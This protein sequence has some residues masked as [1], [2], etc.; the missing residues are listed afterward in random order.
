MRRRKWTRR[1]IESSDRGVGIRQYMTE[2]LFD[3]ALST[4]GIMREAAG[5]RPTTASKTKVEANRALLHRTPAMCVEFP[6]GAKAG[7]RH[8]CDGGCRL[9]WKPKD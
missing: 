4:K 1:N 9:G 7:R 5:D 8:P 3:I 2:Q 6:L